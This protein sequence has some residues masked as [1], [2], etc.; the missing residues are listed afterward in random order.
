MWKLITEVIGVLL[1]IYF[2]TQ[3][4]L[5][6]FIPGM[7]YFNLHKKQ[8]QKP[9]SQPGT[10]DKLD[11]E[12]TR[13]AEQRKEAQSKADSAEEQVNNIKTKLK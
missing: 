3:L 13:I 1:I 9:D 2:M 8:K 10:L 5:P 12:A 11:E 7:D 6:S 4:V